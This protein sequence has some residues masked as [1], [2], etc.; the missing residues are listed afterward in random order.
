MPREPAASGNTHL[1][2]VG[3]IKGDVKRKAPVLNCLKLDDRHAS[4]ANDLPSK[5]HEMVRSWDLRAEGPNLLCINRSFL[6]SHI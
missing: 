4:P 6:E 5:Q 2:A 1:G 3:D